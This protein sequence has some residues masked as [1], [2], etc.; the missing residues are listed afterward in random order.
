[1][2]QGSQGV[3]RSLKH[4]V[5]AA[6]RVGH[7]IQQLAETTHEIAAG[8]FGQRVETVAV[9]RELVELGQDFNRMSGHVQSYVGQ[10]EQAAQANR[11]LFIGSMRAFTA[12]ID[13]KDPYTKGHSERVAAYSR[14]VSKFLDLSPEMEHR[15]WVGALMHD[16]G[17][18]GIEDRILKK[19]GVLTDDEYEVMKLHPA[20][21]SPAA[22]P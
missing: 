2:A 21:G 8:N 11:E 15:V 13:A 17:K 3:A 10:L 18:I 5:L 7:P 4:A 14:V 19:G 22:S 9:G 20:I 1:M 16:V 12:A 6:R